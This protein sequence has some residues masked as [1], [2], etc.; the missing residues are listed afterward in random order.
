MRDEIEEADLEELMRAIGKAERGYRKVGKPR[1]YDP[2]A[3]RMDTFR[4]RIRLTYYILLFLRGWK[5]RMKKEVDKQEVELWY[6]LRR[7]L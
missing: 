1:I 2:V 7:R 6:L 3:R 5:E 4:R